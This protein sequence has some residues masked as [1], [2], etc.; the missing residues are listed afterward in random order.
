MAGVPA[1]CGAVAYRI[2]RS[3]AGKHVN[4]TVEI[5]AKETA[6]LKLRIPSILQMQAVTANGRA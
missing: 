4:A 3:V 6:K 5:P 1:W 2:Q